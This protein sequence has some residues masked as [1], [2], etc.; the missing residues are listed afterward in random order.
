VPGPAG[1][2]LGVH[3]ALDAPR[4]LLGVTGLPS[5]HLASSRIVN[6]H[7]VKSSFGVP[8][9]G[10]QV[11]D[12]DHLAGLL[13]AGV[14][15]QRPVRQRLLD[16]VAG[17]GPAVGR[18]HRVRTGVAGQVDRDG[19]ARRGA[20]DVGSG[21][22]TVRI[23]ADLGG[24]GERPVGVRVAGVVARAAACGQRQQRGTGDQRQ[25]LPVL[26]V[27]SSSCVHVGRHR[28]RRLHG[29]R[30]TPVADVPGERTFSV[31]RPTGAAL[32]PRWGLAG[33]PA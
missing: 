31:C 23:L 16:R 22:L 1:N 17:D 19:P 32:G 15:R 27:E 28:S 11:G 8:E 13:V 29:R 12:Q 24:I 20:L 21:A 25:W 14:L 5:S 2:G 33:A 9:V 7:S 26:H 4:D 6:F 10:G 3:R 18:V 30:P